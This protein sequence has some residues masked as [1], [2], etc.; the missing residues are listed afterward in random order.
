MN[1]SKKLYFLLLVFGASFFVFSQKNSKQ[2]YSVGFK[3]IELVD[4]SRVY[5]PKVPKEH[6][7]YYRPVDLDI[8]YPSKENI[9]DTLRFKDLFKLLELRATNYQD[10][11]SFVGVTKELAEFYVAELGGHSSA[12]SLLNKR[13]NSSLNPKI[14]KE[15]HPVILYMAGLNGMGFENYRV[16]EK[17]AENGF[18][19]VS[20]WSVGRY[21]GN[22]TN[23]K[24]DMIQQVLDAE[25]ALEYLR[26]EKKINI[27]FDKI[28]VLGCS[29]GGISA[30][31]FAK[32]NKG[33]K[34]MVSFD[35]TETHYFGESETDDDFI[36]EIHGSYF[37]EPYRR[38][39]NYLYF[40]SGDKL[41][42][43]TPTGEFNFRKQLKGDKYYLRYK[44]SKHSDFLCIS[45]VLN[46]SAAS[47]NLYDD[48][49]EATLLFFNKTL[50]NLSG[51]HKYWDVLL[52]QKNT[53]I[54]GC[55]FSTKKENAFPFKGVVIDSKTQELLPY[56]S[57]GVL[58][59]GV[60]TV[61]ND[62]G[63]FELAIKEKFQ[64]DTI[65]VSR[66]GY[67]PKIFLIKELM[68]TNSEV[69]ISLEEEVGQLEEVIIAVKSLKKKVLGN[70][71][72]STFV[73]HLFDYDQL[74]KE[75][76]IKIKIRK[77][78]TYI[79]K[80]NFN[81]AYNRFSA[82]TLFRLNMY[83]LKDGKPNKN[84]LKDNIII[85]VES[86]QTGR[87][88]KDLRAYNIKV[89]EDVLVTLEWVATEGEVYNTEAIQI[90]LQFLAGGTYE[91][92]SS[93]GEMKKI[94]K[95]MGLGYTLEV[96]Q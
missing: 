90:S 20:I 85:P 94:L 21:P 28:G 22:M 24:E 32:R 11:G 14:S 58:N 35:G 55:T 49:S 91:R 5:N 92:K 75:L 7:L 77:E 34:T 43:F 33:V 71:T 69:N 38:K 39:L 67:K 46:S 12:E 78:P 68:K 25:F 4:T 41:S 50:K 17:L 9:K 96:R 8:W 66:V 44:D 53:T 95:G 64:Q 59:R 65:R 81:I 86:N 87:I 83:T 15:K 56:T 3:S 47:V 89:S 52:R 27:N 10:Q 30:A 2:T 74:G 48:I 84:I 19:V 51:F 70:K 63:V 62:K 13:T 23:Q 82:K 60:G 79:D 88:S 73:S 1:F 80:F 36:K 16:L 37:T 61:S 6:S 54:E 40:E 45:S 72:T 26:S 29:W 31:V 93:Q 76:G 42:D 57:I 18:I